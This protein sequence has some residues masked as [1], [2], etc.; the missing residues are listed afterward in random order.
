MYTYVRLDD[1]KCPYCARIWPVPINPGE[2]EAEEEEEEDEV[3]GEQVE[4]N[5]PP[6]IEELTHLHNYQSRKRANDDY[7]VL[8]CPNDWCT[9]K[10]EVTDKRNL[11]LA[12]LAL[13]RYSY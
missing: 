2:Y 12:N 11:S 8:L 13:K 1:F 3:V 9:Y 7:C 4:T 6:P 10:T 5:S